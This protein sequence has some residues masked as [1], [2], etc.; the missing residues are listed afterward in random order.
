MDFK[1]DKRL[2]KTLLNEVLN[3]PNIS[4]VEIINNTIYFN[5][6]S[7]INIFQLQN[8]CFTWAIDNDYNFSFDKDKIDLINSKDSLIIKSLTNLDNTYN[9]IHTF[10]LCE[11]ILSKI[12]KYMPNLCLEVIK[13]KLVKEKEPIINNNITTINIPKG[14]DLI[15]FTDGACS[16]NPGMGGYGGIILFENNGDFIENIG[17]IDIFTKF[18]GSSKDITTNNK[19]ELTAI[20]FAFKNMKAKYSKVYNDSKI[21]IYSDSKYCVDGFNSWIKGWIKNNWKNSKKK[22]VENK[23]LWQELVKY[24]DIIFKDTPIEL[25][26]VKAHTG[27]DDVFSKYN[28]IADELATD[29]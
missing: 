14:I 9:P 17:D 2:L 20:L 27:N 29:F 18:N 23:E 10:H 4:S 11:L 26:W 12:G 3:I 8:Q 21:T 24:R 22:D 1:I 5:K 15:S 16:G 28:A 13:P 25:K 6:Y 19:M 7:E